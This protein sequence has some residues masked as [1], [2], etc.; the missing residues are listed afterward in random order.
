[1]PRHTGHKGHLAQEQGAVPC[2]A[3]FVALL[4]PGDRVFVGEQVVHE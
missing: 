3:D 1:M 2:D 4:E